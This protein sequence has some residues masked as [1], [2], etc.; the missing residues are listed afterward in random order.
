M[1]I[2]VGDQEAVL[3]VA[4]AG[5]RVRG[6]QRFDRHL[7]EQGTVRAEPAAADLLQHLAPRQRR[8]DSLRCHRAQRF[9][10]DCLREQSRAEGL[11][12]TTAVLEAA[13][14]QGE[15]LEPVVDGLEIVLRVVDQIQQLLN[16]LG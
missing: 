2:R 7:S 3:L 10:R 16:A 13:E 14:Q 8:P 6:G 11:A 1:T 9:L 5:Q 12:G 15:A 4:R